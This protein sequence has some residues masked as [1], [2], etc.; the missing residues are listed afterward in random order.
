M[1]AQDAPRAQW[2]RVDET[3]D[4]RS[5]VR[6]LDATRS[7]LLR[8]AIADPALYFAYLEL[9]PGFA[10]LD[11]GAGTGDFDRLLAGLVGPTGRVVGVDYGRTM[12]EE[13]TAR[14]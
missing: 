14:A 6:L 9:A 4:P 3:S 13:A 10:V 7:R 1:G 2:A 8:V 11:V 12:V 5:F